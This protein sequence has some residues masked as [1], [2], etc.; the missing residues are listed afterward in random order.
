MI[1][2]SEFHCNTCATE[3]STE[4]IQTK[5]SYGIDVAYVDCPECDS[6]YNMMFD[7]KATDR[8][9]SKIKRLKEIENYLQL[10]LYREMLIAEDDYYRQTYNDFPEEDKKLIGE[11][12]S[13]VDKKKIK[14]YNRI[15]KR[16]K[17]SLKD[18][19]KLL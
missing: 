10:T 11:Y 14:E 9:K 15:I 17:Y 19:M 1:N 8:I 7:N 6:T 3:L 4:Q 18:L 5:K 16:D 2:V 12:Q 13:D